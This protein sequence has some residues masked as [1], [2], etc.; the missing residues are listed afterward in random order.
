[1]GTAADYDIAMIK[2]D[3]RNLPTCPWGDGK[4]VEI[5]QWVAT[6]RSA[7]NDIVVGVVSVGLRKIP[8]R[9][10]VLGVMLLDATG[11]PKVL[12]VAPASG[13][14][15]AGVLVDDLITSVD[16]HAI[17]SRDDL[18]EMIQGRQL[19]ERVS[20]IVRR[21]DNDVD[22]TVVLGQRP[23]GPPTRGEIMNA[24][25]GALSK[26]STGFPL[27]LQH[28]TVLKPSDCGGPLVNLDGKVIGINIARA[29][30][31]E[32]YALP[33]DTVLA[34]L[35]E[36]KAGKRIPSTQPATTRPFAPRTSL[37]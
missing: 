16:G 34:L 24:M 31:T 32:S 12:Q 7:S 14:Q 18:S 28:D 4:P 9:N 19:G 10:A 27:V 20:L 22:L 13:A 37:R 30:R 8:S 35:D 21:G 15:K 6:P 36:L 33:A 17:R 29:G 25:G 11:G 3:A 5:G 2:V 26:R 23:L 1:M